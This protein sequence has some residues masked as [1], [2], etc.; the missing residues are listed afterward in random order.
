MGYV[1]TVEW[2]TGH[3][4]IDMQHKQLFK[5]VNDLL[6]ACA[7]GKGRNYIEKTL[8]FLSDYVDE[9]FRD[10]EKLQQQYHYPDRLKHIML[11][12]NFRRTVAELASQLKSE[13]PTVSLVAKV[14]SSVGG[15]LVVHIQ[16]EDKKLAAHI[17]SI[18][19]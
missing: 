3:P 10:E 14:N 4:T 12:E 19:A 17:R 8:T 7:A 1:W 6:D 2:A 16:Q 11:H 9:H 15:W 18:A 5:A 13:G